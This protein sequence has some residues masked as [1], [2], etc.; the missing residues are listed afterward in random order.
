MLSLAVLI[1]GAGQAAPSCP[2][3]V[4]QWGYA[5]ANSVAVLGDLAVFGAGS[6]L[7]TA[8]VSD[9]TAPRLL[10]EL[11]L[12]DAP[13]DIEI[14]GSLAFVLTRS[15]GL[16]VV[17]LSAPR[18][19]RE[20]GALGD[21]WD[22]RKLALYGSLALLALGAD[23]LR[24]VDV[25]D[26]TRPTEV[27]S[28]ATNRDAVDVVVAGD[29][30]FLG[31]GTEVQV[32]DLADPGSPRELGGA[33][34]PYPV[35]GIAL[36]DELLYVVSYK[37]DWRY[38]QSWS[39]LQVIDV[40]SPEEPVELARETS[41]I[42]YLRDI[43]L[44]GCHALVSGGWYVFDLTDPI[45]P[46][47]LPLAH[48]PAT[49]R[50][51]PVDGLA[52]VAASLQG[53]VILD[54]AD[55]TAAVVLGSIPTPWE[56]GSVTVDG[57]LV[58]TAA[59]QQ[60]VRVLDV[61]DPRDPAPVALFG[62]GGA[63]SIVGAADARLVLHS[64]GT[65]R[66]LDLA[67]PASPVELGQVEDLG[68]VRKAVVAEDLALVAT[69]DHGLRV[70]DLAAPGGPRLV[71]T[72][73]E[74]STVQSLAAEGDL[75]W[76]SS[77]T[78]AGVLDLGEPASPRVL[79][80]L[81]EMA[82]EVKDAAL[83]GRTLCLTSFT[84]LWVV[85]LSEPSEPVLTGEFALPFASRT[86]NVAG[87]LAMLS[88]ASYETWPPWHLVRFVDLSV[89]GDPA[90]VGEADLGALV[91]MSPDG[92][93]AVSG[94]VGV[95]VYEL[96]GCRAPIPEVRFS[97][98][99][100]PPH[101]GDP[102]QF[103]DSSI[104]RPT[105]WR[106]DFG[107]GATSTEQN[108][109]HTFTPPSPKTV[110]LTAGNDNG[111]DTLSQT[112][113]LRSV[114]SFSWDPP[115]PYV[116]ELVQ[117]E[118]YPIPLDARFDWQLDD[119]T[120]ATGPY[121]RHAF[122]TAGEHQVS[123]TTSFGG[124]SETTTRTITVQPFGESAP[125]LTGAEAAFQVVPVAAHAPGA[126][127]TTWRTDLLIHGTT[128][129]QPMVSLYF[130][131]EVSCGAPVRSRQLEARHGSML[132][133]D[134]V[135]LLFG[136]DPGVGAIVV[137]A[138]RSVLLSSRTYT[139][140][141]GGTM[142]QGIPAV[143][144]DAASR[145]TEDATL[146]QLTESDR[147]RTNLGVV[148]PSSAQINVQV[149]ALS[150]AGA[151]L[152]VE[153]WTVPALGLLQVN[154][155]LRRFA[156][157]PVEDAYALVS[158]PTGIPF[159]AY[160]SVV[161]NATGDPSFVSPAALE[162]GPLVIAAASHADGLNGTTWRT[163]LEV[164][165]PSPDPRIYR[166]ELLPGYPPRAAPPPATLSLEPHACHR[167]DDVLASLFGFAGSGA[168]RIVSEEGALAASSRT[169]ADTA[170]GTFGQSIPAVPECE[171]FSGEQALL[172]QLSSSADPDEGFRTNV[173]LVNLADQPAEVRLTASS[174]NWHHLGF[175]R[176]PVPP[177]SHRQLSDL[178]RVLGAGTVDAASVRVWVPSEGRVIPYASVV[179]NA[180]GDPTFIP[181]R[182]MP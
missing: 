112:L 179:D 91:A 182:R 18:Q 38:I 149:E 115:N 163:Q 171:A 84:R 61:S 159:V 40:S 120:S 51:E 157:G 104:G 100:A 19:P 160:A 23:G 57:H 81:P 80:E 134:A 49:G 114:S 148:N 121:L 6:V 168:L 151:L 72:A 89:P 71:A 177:R 101:P 5:G 105:W 34:T 131:P 75:A 46:V 64:Q 99:P 22:G 94:G 126:L 169:Y 11:Q 178:L 165:N 109:S 128:Y 62:L 141:A 164:C 60:G 150:A 79:A 66:V 155:F 41:R 47:L 119:G 4:G 15:R 3:L 106:W 53:L 147:F 93:L 143:T 107:G 27:G 67:D 16:R 69:L 14:R 118:V 45:H 28:F 98:S 73:F 13:A 77:S 52:Y 48:L 21:T 133:E 33:S 123:L 83:A 39:A 111:N 156:T 31:A 144:V 78:W 65:L 59:E 86:V 50:L 176:V 161:E 103:T 1:G 145:S 95:R 166:V 108:P 37:Y 54:V 35:T 9:P 180:T 138:D 58:Y 32:V 87:D 158:Q 88:D 24:V 181:A 110:T 152:G 127:G 139:V 17:D 30:A 116:A 173:G 70:V 26:P 36:R 76:V 113:A 124:W 130:L 102:V 55:P 90:I 96:Q 167:H 146:V 29:H 20:L 97:W 162:D 8:D 135:R 153:T 7:M 92:A 42:T 63:W 142:G 154:R 10:G 2:E 132:F 43:E 140:T 56:T 175:L 170:D 12:E 125:P 44:S 82:A 172:L 74:G 68:Q 136:V 137:V 174:G 129:E 117:L 122:A 25:S 85:D